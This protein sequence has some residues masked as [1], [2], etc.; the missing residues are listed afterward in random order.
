MSL[1]L[2]DYFFR[3]NTKSMIH[4]R[5]IG[6]MDFKIKNF[7]SV[8]DPVKKGKKLEPTQIFTNRRMDNKIV[9]YLYNEIWPSNKNEW[10]TYTCNN[11]DDP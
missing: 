11:T 3:H 1:G 4:E 9:V 8:K 2:A 6:K 7:C 10:T 5:K